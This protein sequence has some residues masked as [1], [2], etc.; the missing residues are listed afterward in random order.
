MPGPTLLSGV[1]AA[2]K[3]LYPGGVST[4]TNTKTILH[5]KLA[6]K[7]DFVGESAYVVIQNA[8]SQGVGKTVADSQAADNDP[9]FK[10]FN[11]TRD[12]FFATAEI[13]GEA[14]EAAVRTEG[15]LVDLVEN[16]VG[17]VEKVMHCD[18]AIYEYGAGNAIRG[19]IAEVV[20]ADTVFRLT[21]TTNMNYFEVG[22]LL[23]CLDST[24]LNPAQQGSTRLV[25]GIDR[26]N[27]RITISA[28]DSA[29]DVGEYLVRATMQNGVSTYG[30][31]HG[32]DSYIAGGTAPG[33]LY[34]LD[35]NSDPVR[36]AGQRKDYTGVA[37]EDAVIDASA[38]C[39]I[40]GLETP[41]V[42]VAN[43]LQISAL[44]QSVGGKIV[45]N[46]DASSKAG[47]G[48]SELVFETENG[49]VTVLSDP[50]C[51]LQRAYLL[52]MENWKLWSLRK[53]PHMER[54]QGQNMVSYTDDK[55]QVRWKFYGAMR[56]DAPGSNFALTGFGAS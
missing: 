4:A 33:T 42:L 26:I 52:R 34:S 31:F 13:D 2:L 38:L 23:D 56:C 35:R 30:T 8:Y 5:N 29:W 9:S 3:I 49:T 37:M 39:T 27:K 40:Q 15:A 20:V 48:F 21:D 54:L 14:A 55:F 41:N 7:E 6:K 44:K 24:G 22:M 25:T 50:F 43:P 16:K 51:P 18:L 17:G 19:Q 11:L 32:L 47:V 53:A 1:T 45:Y 28:T 46:R 12:K 10:R 36:L